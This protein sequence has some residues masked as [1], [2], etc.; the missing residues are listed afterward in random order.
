MGA[1]EWGLGEYVWPSCCPVAVEIRISY[2]LLWNTDELLFFHNLNSVLYSE[3]PAFSL[4]FLYFKVS[5]FKWMCIFPVELL[6]DI[7]RVC[8]G[9]TYFRNVF[10][11]LWGVVWKSF[12]CGKLSVPFCGLSSWDYLI[13]S[14]IFKE[15]FWV[16]IGMNCSELHFPPPISRCGLVGIRAEMNK[17]WRYWEKTLMGKYYQI[18]CIPLTL[19]SQAELLPL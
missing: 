11:V 9:M 3:K 14:Y 2:H 13:P 7:F 10:P 16:E 17:E 18:P 5:F 19:F 8:E 6:G 4:W 12:R 1:G 15:T